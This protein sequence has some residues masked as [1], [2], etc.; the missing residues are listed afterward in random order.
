MKLDSC[1]ARGLLPPEGEEAPE[2]IRLP[3]V[4][5]YSCILV[6]GHVQIKET[7]YPPS[8]EKAL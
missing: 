2:Y 1:W 7:R 8:T 5:F 3:K 4:A 6:H